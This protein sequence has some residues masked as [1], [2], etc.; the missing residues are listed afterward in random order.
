MPITA[1]ELKLRTNAIPRRVREQNDSFQVTYRRR[2]E[3]CIV[4]APAQAEGSVGPGHWPAIDE[5]AEAISAHW[6]S[7]VRAAG[8]VSE[9]RRSPP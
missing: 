8:V 6:P 4:S 2:A 3:A 5:L 9:G 1:S 7:N